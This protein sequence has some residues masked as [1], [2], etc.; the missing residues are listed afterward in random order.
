MET[1]TPLFLSVCQSM[2]Y[3]EVGNLNIDSLRG[4]IVCCVVAA[5][6]EWVMKLNDLILLI[7][8]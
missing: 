8:E 2:G 7:E 6:V 4:G 1:K 3:D 5:Q